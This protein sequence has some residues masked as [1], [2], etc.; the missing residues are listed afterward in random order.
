[1]LQFW[2]RRYEALPFQQKISVLPWIVAAALALVLV[3]TV[4]SGLVNQYR[5]A[6]IERE[7]YPDV[8]VMWELQ[9]DL[10]KLQRSFQ[11]AASASDTG[12]L[13]HSDSLRELM[14]EALILEAD[15]SAHVVLM[16]AVDEYHDVAR[17][18]T[19]RMINGETGDAIVAAVGAMSQQYH[20]LRE[21]VERDL[22]ADEAAI[23]ED[24][25][26]AR[27]MQMAGWGLALLVTI[28]C[29]GGMLFLSRFAV[30]S[31][32]SPLR[33]AAAAAD[34]LARGDLDVELEGHDRDEIGRLLRSM[35]EMVAYLREMSRVADAV[36]GGDVD[37]AVR[38]R[39]DGDRFG[40]AFANMTASL[41]DMAT[42]ADA[43][44][45]GDLTVQVR[46]R[47]DRDRFGHA[48]V[49]MIASLSNVLAE[50]HD[51]AKAIASASSQL[52]GSAQAMSD[53]ANDE[54]ASVRQTTHH[55]LQA[56]T[57]IAEH[58]ERSQGM[59][60]TAL[61]GAQDAEESGRALRETLD[62]MQ[63]IGEKIG[64]IDRIASQTNLLALNAAIEA[65]RAGDHGRG[66]AV[67][68]AEVRTLAEQS[69]V[70]AHDIGT[71]VR[72]SRGVAERSGGQ[73]ATLVASIRET[74]AQVETAVVASEAQSRNLVQVATAMDQV[75]EI[76]Q[77]N[78]AGAQELAAMAEEL[79][80]Q[81]DALEQLMG[82]FRVRHD[83]GR[84][85]GIT[86]GALVPA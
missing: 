80:A 19:A 6:R 69:R 20:A 54:A 73:L 46:A 59:R 42:V 66:F 15:D 25:Y 9:S 75:T 36:A 65:A 35:N 56:R 61:K 85:P 86:L 30:R 41:R 67:V 38:A 74:A 55:V 83:A 47:S 76:S 28:G 13:A 29:F 5:L 40:V 64:I 22:Q 7:R 43:I 50:L 82:N 27:M 26:A 37:V 17:A 12:L 18:T 14:R 81:G 31:L 57:S 58:A 71:L 45:S 72:E 49:R 48:F 53:G 16:R 51:S 60:T 2:K 4:G 34:R 62:A 68:A 23:V 21:R 52:T 79:S 63:A 32:V 11:D 78:A 8:R 33:D 39:S 77:R 70:A 1:M 10:A 84:R 3:I 24:F 44:S